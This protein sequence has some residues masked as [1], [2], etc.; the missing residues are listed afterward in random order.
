MSGS[1]A[2]WLGLVVLT[3]VNLFNYLD[4]Y[5]LA[6]VVESLKDS[7]LALTD[8]QAGSLM[9]GFV[10]V[11]MMASPAFGTLGD[12]GNRTKLV[13]LGVA[14]WSVA[15]AAGGLA[16]SFIALF[17]ARAAVGVGE[18]AYGTIAPAMLAD[19]FP[20][21]L[22]GRVFSVFFCAIPVGAALGYILGGLMDQAFGWR[23][24]FFIA[25][26]PGLALAGLVLLLK[27]PPRGANDAPSK[28]EARS[29]DGSTWRAYLAMMRNRTYALTVLGYGAYT[30][31]LGGLAFWMPAFLERVRGVPKEDATV[32]FGIIVVITGLVGTG[33]GGWLGDY[34]LRWTKSAYLW[35]SGVATL[36][37]VPF[38]F[39]ALMAETPAV[40]M[41]GIVMA[42]VLLFVS[43]GPVNSAIVNAV[44]PDRRAT[45]VALS[46]FVMHIL[47]D[48]PSPPLIGMIS[49]QSSLATG[50]LVVPVAVLVAGLIWCW[51]AWRGVEGYEDSEAP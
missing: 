26:L 39:M 32:Q 18:A 38:G 48:V 13:A 43:T 33:I 31:A 21:R 45:A 12:R 7:E 44:A 23:A 10:I 25:G 11:Y 51:A 41:T 29:T 47:G 49:D 20:K 42:E 5:I 17:L 24:A 19:Y 2:A 16:G 8:S 37:A 22:R 34:L 30:F 4:R 40:Y 15:T 1:R 28:A 35:V 14:I 6:A 50:V 9:T 46:I 36:L 27:D 3:A